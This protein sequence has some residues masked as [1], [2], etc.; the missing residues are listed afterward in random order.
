MTDI[1][2]LF[3]GDYP[4]NADSVIYINSFDQPIG[5]WD[6]RNVTNM[7]GM[8]VY[9][10]F[11]QDISRWCVSQIKSEPEDFLLDAILESYPEKK[12]KWG[13]CPD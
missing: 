12:P 10:N 2:G 3:K 8:L 1:S 7:G 13:T 9:S 5:N 11:D 6:V 4:D